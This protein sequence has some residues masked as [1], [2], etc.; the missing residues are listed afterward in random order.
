EFYGGV[1][2][3]KAGIRYA[4]QVTAV[5]PTYAQEI[6]TPEGG[7]GLDGVLRE[8]RHALTGILNGTDTKSWN[9]NTDSHI[10]ARYSSSEVS[11]KAVCKAELVRIFRFPDEPTIPI[12]AVISRLVDQKGMDVLAAALGRLVAMRLRIVILGSGERQ[13]ERLFADWAQ[14]Y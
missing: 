10:A 8:R 2:F 6:C 9:P 7:F 12:L 13:Y 3:M 14:R 5:S 1:N 4:D 11:G